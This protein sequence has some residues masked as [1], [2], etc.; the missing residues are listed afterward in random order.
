[1]SVTAGL[2]RLIGIW[3]TGLMKGGK[4]DVYGVF[5]WDPKPQHSDFV[6]KYKHQDI[7][8][9]VIDAP[10][11][12]L[13]SDPPQ[14]IGDT[15]FDAAWQDLL[16]YCP[17]F[18]NLQRLDKLCGLGKYAVMVIGFDD[19]GKLDKPLGP[20]KPGTLRKVLYMQPYAEG[21]IK[22]QAWDTNENSARYGLPEMYSIS[23]GK[24][25]DDAPTGTL[26]SKPL[27]NFNVHWSRVLHV[28][29]GALESPVYGESRLSSC[30]NVLDDILKVAGGSAET[31]WLTANRGLHI[32]VDKDVEIQPED[33]ADLQAEIEEYENNLR[34]VIRT[35]A[36]EINSLG[37]D[38]PDPRGTFDILLSLLASNTGI[39]KR[40]LAGSEAGQ[41]ASQ[42]D[43]ANWA[44]RIQERIT[45]YGQPIVLIPMV[46]LLI[47]A[48][49]LPSPTSLHIEWPDAFKMNPLERAQTSAQ[50][51]RSSANIAKT[52]KT[53]DEMNIAWAEAAQPR[54][55]IMPGIGGG[56]GFFGN[57][58]PPKPEP[59]PKSGTKPDP[60]KPADQTQETEVKELP[61]LV[62]AREP[63]ELI[64][65]EEG[66]S[67][68]GFGKHQPVFDEKT[69]S[70]PA[71]VKPSK[72]ELGA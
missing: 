35:R 68:I 51:A 27:N 63:L 34:R 8:K 65:I 31:F 60:N 66:R 54:Q 52:L 36:A 2:E 29:D 57:A 30:Y 6:H 48:G 42:Q 25:T 70:T 37:S 15:S 3:R 1:M 38:V 61:P 26:L 72:G 56:G 14:L 43:R 45:E 23:P 33:A 71:P 69:D 11:N 19:G 32:N 5:G 49:V 13:W 67:I 59:K 18:F 40:V 55:Q 28:A 39:P 50:M 12:A 24:F 62:D 53:M 10:V 22:I 64:S 47:N 17:V 41:L 7:A 4:R 21:S 16:S 9:R 44:Q 20:S 58:E 46:K